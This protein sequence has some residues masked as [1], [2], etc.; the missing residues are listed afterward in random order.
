MCITLTNLFDSSPPQREV[1]MLREYYDTLIMHHHPLSLA[2]CRDAMTNGNAAFGLRRRMRCTNLTSL[3]ERL[4][5][6]CY[7]TSITP[8]HVSLP[9][10]P[11]RCWRR[12]RVACNPSPTYVNNGMGIMCLMSVVQLCQLAADGPAKKVPSSVIH[13]LPLL[14]RMHKSTAPLVHGVACL[15][16]AIPN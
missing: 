14:P 3:S 12:T 9:A 15:L 2:I 16:S 13:L 4:R 7:P 10:I 5:V 1:L 8:H 11:A 6:L